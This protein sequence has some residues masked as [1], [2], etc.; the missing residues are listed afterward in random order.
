MVTLSWLTLKGQATGCH[1]LSAQDT[2]MVSHNDLVH[3]TT[4]NCSEVLN[5]PKATADKDG[6]RVVFWDEK[7]IP[8]KEALGS[9]QHFNVVEMLI[10]LLFLLLSHTFPSTT[11]SEYPP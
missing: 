6:S 4:S 2:G 8:E 1:G 10:T 5:K 11:M 9:S 7:K 3:P